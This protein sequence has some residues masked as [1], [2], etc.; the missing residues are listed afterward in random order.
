LG[1]HPAVPNANGGTTS[2]TNWAWVNGESWTAFDSLN[3]D[4]AQDEPDEPTGDINSALAINRYGNSHWNDEGSAWFVGGYIVQINLVAT[5][6]VRAENGSV[7]GATLINGGNCY[8]NTPTVRIIG[9]GNGAQAV[10]VVNNGVVTAI[11]ILAAGSGYTNTP[12]LLIAPPFIP[13]PIISASSLLLGPLVT[14]VLELNLANLS[15]YENYQLQ[16]SPVAGGT[17]TNFGTP[18]SPTATRSTQYVN[19]SGNVGFFRLSAVQ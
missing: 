13:Q 15:P 14:P 2:T 4:S 10:A 11:N 18:F 19:A 1:A 8:T 3:F 16:F 7:I 5:A 9:D 6:T 17:W 12:I